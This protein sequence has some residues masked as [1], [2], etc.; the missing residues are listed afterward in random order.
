MKSL[1]L[2][3]N[4][5]AV[6]LAASSL[7]L[8]V[9]A[10]ADVKVMAATA[11]DPSIPVFRDHITGQMSNHNLTVGGEMNCVLLRDNPSAK[12][13]QI[14]VSVVDNSSVLLGNGDV[15]C[16]ARAFNRFGTQSSIGA[17]VK[18]TGTN[19][20]GTVLTL[21]IPAL[22]FV[23]GSYVVKCILPRR[24]AGDANSG[25]ASIRYVESDPAP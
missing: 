9:P 22:T 13:V 11:C 17:T 19:S 21:P 5:F 2:T 7:S 23:D 1:A 3:S 16:N 14:Q 6:F 18:T 20:A 15:S 25:V 4:P 24:G 10:M 8:A 12:I